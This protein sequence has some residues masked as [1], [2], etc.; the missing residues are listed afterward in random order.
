MAIYDAYEQWEDG[1]FPAVLAIGDSWF[2][3][4]NNNILQAIAQHPK[5]KA[6][7]ANMVRLGQNGA[8]LLDYVNLNGRPGK[9]ADQLTAQLKPKVLQYFSAFFVSGAG[10]DAVDY[11]LGLKADCSGETTAQGCISADGMSQLMKEITGSMSLLL[12]EVL[13]AC[14]EQ[15]HPMRII[16]HC[17]D[18]AVP[19]GRGFGL[20]D[21]TLAGPWLQPAMNK[22]KVPQDMVLRKGVIQILI[23]RLHD[24]FALY[25]DPANDVYFVDSRGVLSSQDDTYRGDWA[26]ELHPTPAGFAKVVNQRWYDVLARAGLA[27]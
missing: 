8:L 4:P 10:N 27:F 21:L 3:Y 13:W 19:D 16:F 23:D 24:A 20:P 26:N 18:Y 22:C 11:T 12:H 15:N 25:A 9:Y 7:Y 14:N 17:Y 1:V 6:P 5:L 2:W